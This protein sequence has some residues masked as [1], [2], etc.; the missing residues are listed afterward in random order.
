MQKKI[1]YVLVLMTCCV[2][3]ITGLQL[4]W[5][6]QNYQ[7]T[8]R[9]YKTEVNNALDQAVNKERSL[10]QGE[11][12]SKVKHWLAD[13]SF[14]NI[15]CN[16]NNRDS[17]TVFTIQDVH[18][19]FLEDTARKVK[20]FQVG[21]YKF[22]QK[23]R[24][25]TPAAKTIFIDHFA[26]NMLKRDLEDGSIFYYTQG[27]GDSI[28]KAFDES[29]LNN[30]NLAI[31][32]KKELQE[33]TIYSEFQL[34]P[35]NV[36]LTG[37]FQTTKINT[38]LRR[39]FEIQLV[40]ARLENPNNYYLKEMKWLIITSLLLIGITLFC[41]YYTIK[42]LFNQNKL[43]A[44]K[45]QFISNMTHELHTPL[46][47]IQ[48]TTEALQKF[49]PDAATQA[50]YLDIILYQ[51]KKLTELTKEILTNAK[52]E[53]LGF[54][55]DEQI[56]LD[57]LVLVA[58]TDLKLDD[59]ISIKYMPSNEKHIIIGNKM[60]LS[61]AIGNIIENAAKYNT[62]PQPVIEIN[63]NKNLKEMEISI[64]DN[65]PGIADEFKQKIFDQFYRISTG[66]VHDIK[67]YGLGLSYVKKV[68]DQH[69]GS[70]SVIDKYPT[71]SV[72]LINLPNDAK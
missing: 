47:S 59:N 27:L 9:N 42:T 3:G 62:N 10:R 41:F 70:I 21:L 22:K 5:N 20:F 15:E 46:A 11:I 25:I 32:Y 18:P 39:P 57:E 1:V 35:T 71:G 31:L 56:D 29:R 53:A 33:R 8:V 69:H 68:I 66:N 45:D 19:R 43:V 24:K 4:Y 58:I 52:L 40:W 12:I 17:N 55:K 38:S 37:Y 60:H 54:T 65:G 16:I 34:N 6:Y 28:S 49:T 72:F 61:H 26:E 63:I 64:A 30:R 50:N 67:G 51:T 7:T 14:I 48:I 23:L 44:L 36:P 2:L 13:T